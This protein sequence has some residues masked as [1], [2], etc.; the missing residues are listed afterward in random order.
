M[1]DKVKE[2]LDMLGEQL[3]DLADQF[4]DLSKESTV[5]I[6]PGARIVSAVDDYR[7]LLRGINTNTNFAR[8]II[9]TGRDTLEEIEEELNINPFS[10]DYLTQ[11]SGAVAHIKSGLG[12]INEEAAKYYAVLDRAKQTRNVRVLEWLS[13]ISF[14]EFLKVLA[15]SQKLADV[16]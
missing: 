5:P 1:S 14:D 4:K 2:F 6:K 15:D 9:K 3:H 13:T 16:F 7:L 10:V 12:R 11:Y 8:D